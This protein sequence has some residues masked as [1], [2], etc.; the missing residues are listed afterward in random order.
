MWKTVLFL[1]I[2]I[3]VIPF[4]AFRFDDPLSVLQKAVLIKLLYVYLAAAILC[5]IVSSVSNN[6]SQVDKLWSTIPIAYVWIVAFES[7]FEPRLILMASLVSVWGIR[8]SYNFWRR[9][10]YSKKGA[11]PPDWWRKTKGRPGR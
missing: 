10:G 8:L 7:G 2:T 11:Q 1:L 6:Y 3:I 5:F 9:G 4:I